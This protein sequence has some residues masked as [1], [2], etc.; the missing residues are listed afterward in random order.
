MARLAQTLPVTGQPKQPLVAAMRLL[1][2]DDRGLDHAA[3]QVALGTQRVLSEVAFRGLLPRSAVATFVRTDPFPLG[4]RSQTFGSCGHRISSAAAQPTDQARQL[5]DPRTARRAPYRTLQPSHSPAQGIAVQSARS[6]RDP[7]DGAQPATGHA[8]DRPP[9]VIG[10]DQSADPSPLGGCGRRPMALDAGRAQAT[11]D[12]R[13]M[14]RQFRGDLIQR[15]STGSQAHDPGRE[16]AVDQSHA[17]RLSIGLAPL[18]LFSRTDGRSP[19][20]VSPR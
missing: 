9:R 14:H 3:L 19:F 17:A 13:P 12:A 6:R 7:C 4:F 10:R 2:I 20:Q 8:G 15:K 1:V 18:Q 16:R 11:I 5:D